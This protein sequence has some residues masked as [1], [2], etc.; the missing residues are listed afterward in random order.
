MSGSIHP[1]RQCRSPAQVIVQARKCLH[2]EY[3]NGQIDAA[4]GHAVR[5]MTA[6]EGPLRTAGAQADRSVQRSASSSSATATLKS[7]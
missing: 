7:P 3:E 4:K 1:H 6:I 2:G 5:S